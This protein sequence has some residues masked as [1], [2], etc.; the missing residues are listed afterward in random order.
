VRR[1]R[2]RLL[3]PL[4]LAVVPQVGRENKVGM[5]FIII[6]LQKLKPGAVNYGS[7][8]TTL[9]RVRMRCRQSRRAARHRLGSRHLGTADIARH[10]IQRTL[11]PRLFT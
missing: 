10:V 3:L 1:L 6:Y 5:R 9:P 4:R 8:C 11:N 7:T 2:P